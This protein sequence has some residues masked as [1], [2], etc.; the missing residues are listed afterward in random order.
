MNEK[1]NFGKFIWSLRMPYLWILLIVVPL[2]FLIF[3]MQYP[4]PNFRG[5]SVS[6]IAAAF[7]HADAAEWPV[8]YSKFLSLI[9]YFSHSDTILVSFQYL[10]LELSAL[11][12]LFSLKYFIQFGKVVFNI[13]F[14]F[15]VFNPLFLHLGNYIMSDGLFISL[16]LLWITQLLWILYRPSPLQIIPHALIL[17]CLFTVRYNALFYP[18]VSSLAFVLSSL[19]RSVKIAGILLSIVL[20][21]LFIGYTENKFYALN[22]VRQFSPFGGWQLANNALYMYT[23]VELKPSAEVPTQFQE[24]DSVIRQSFISA[25]KKGMILNPYIKDYYIWDGNSPL[26]QYLK[27]KW[28]GDTMTD[29]FTKWASM[30]PLYSDYGKYLIQEHPAAYLGHFVSPNMSNFFQPT[31]ADLGYYNQGTNSIDYII[32]K[33]FDYKTMTMT[34]VPENSELSVIRPYPFFMAIFNF[35]FLLCILL[36]VLFNEFKKLPRAFNHT[37]IV[38]TCFWLL[39]FLF[40]TLASSIELRYQ[41]FQLILNVFFSIISIELLIKFSN[42]QKQQIITVGM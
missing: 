2:E 21:G 16:S 39:N 7:M 17:L 3:K 6:Y 13:V 8:G 30:G 35:C 14:A 9:H 38:I 36:F 25:R 11:L 19:R 26:M 41:V 5:D 22:G 28:E 34:H 12:F 42:T 24:L 31:I 23:N 29:M 4:Y 32:A 33:W 10:L 18:L 15:I 27:Y 1:V 40:S 37:A 20:I